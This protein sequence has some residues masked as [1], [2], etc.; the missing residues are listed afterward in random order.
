MWFAFFIFLPEGTCY[1]SHNIDL[2]VNPGE[3]KRYYANSL[4][5]ACSI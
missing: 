3:D 1:Y 4:F 2:S 5:T